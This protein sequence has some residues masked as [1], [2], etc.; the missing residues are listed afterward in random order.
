MEHL[1]HSWPWHALEIIGAC[2]LTA[3]VLNAL[4]R[5]VARTASHAV[6]EHHHTCT[7]TTPIQPGPYLR[8]H[9]QPNT[10]PTPAGPPAPPRPPSGPRCGEAAR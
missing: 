4:V 8:L 7:G 6:A 10:R 2:Q 9:L 1:G 3:A 5:I